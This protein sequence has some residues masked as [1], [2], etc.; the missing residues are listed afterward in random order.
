VVSTIISYYSDDV[1]LIEPGKG[2]IPPNSH[3]NIKMT[4]KGSLLP[5]A[6]E[7]EIECLV[8]WVPHIIDETV[9]QAGEVT[10]IGDEFLYLR[11]KKRS[12][13]VRLRINLSRRAH[14][15]PVL[16]SLMSHYL[17]MS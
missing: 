2:K 12:K 1:L 10:V 4:L 5:S 17:K 11:V 16:M 13:I 3:I 6:Y 14:Q 9:P 7:G 15:R 8:S